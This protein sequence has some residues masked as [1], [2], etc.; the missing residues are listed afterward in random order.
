MENSFSFSI[1]SNT[2]K[3][4]KRSL[5]LISGKTLKKKNENTKVSIGTTLVSYYTEILLEL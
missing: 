1:R 5:K 3:E 2:V 4:T